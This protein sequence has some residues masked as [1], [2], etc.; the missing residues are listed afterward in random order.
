M[1]LVCV[2]KD[3]RKYD[4]TYRIQPVYRAGDAG[5]STDERPSNDFLNSHMQQKLVRIQTAG[6]YR[7][8]SLSKETY[9]GTNID[10]FV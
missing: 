3:L 2:V 7:K 6:Q 1:D 8:T 10:V 5:T 4:N 9:K